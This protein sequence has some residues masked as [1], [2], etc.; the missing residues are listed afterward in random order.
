MVYQAACQNLR[1]GGGFGGDKSGTDVGVVE[2]LL[3]EQSSDEMNM[4]ST[5]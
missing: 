1:E 4:S 2:G 5:L 3:V